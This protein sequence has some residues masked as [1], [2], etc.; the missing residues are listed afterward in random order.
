MYP[1]HLPPSLNPWPQLPV[2]NNDILRRAGR[3]LRGQKLSSSPDTELVLWGRQAKHG[4]PLRLVGGIKVWCTSV[5]VCCWPCRFVCDTHYNDTW[6]SPPS[7]FSSWMRVSNS[8]LL[9]EECFVYESSAAICKV[10]GSGRCLAVSCLARAA[11]TSDLGTRTGSFACCDDIGISRYDISAQGG[12]C[13]M[14]FI[15]CGSM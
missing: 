5:A 11:V 12:G 7:R 8:T 15:S 9:T 3:W 1:H 6:L 4:I 10:A 2:H 13:F 14:T